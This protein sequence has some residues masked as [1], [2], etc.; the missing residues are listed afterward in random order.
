MGNWNS[1]Q[2]LKFENQRTQPAI[3]L[4]NRIKDCTPKTVMDIGCG[5]GNSTNVMKRFFSNAHIVGIDNSEN[6]IERAKAAYHDI[7]FRCCDVHS[8]EAEYDILFSNA[9]L[10]WVPN[11]KELIPELMRR[12]NPNGVLAV[13]F[14]MNGEEPLYQIIKQV[15]DNVKWGFQNV[16]LDSHGTL[17]PHEYF[18]VLTGCSS[19]FQIW[20]T[21]YY[22]NLPDHKALVEWV[23]G[24]RI[25][26]YLSHLS[27]EQG[28]EF[29]QEIIEK[30]KEIYPI[31]KNGQVI[32]CFRRFFFVAMR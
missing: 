25:R 20:E 9:C 28:V 29:E 14:P 13:Q 19:E 7:E 21:K 22:H 31:M 32:L 1:E 4:A 5:P 8:I 23:K 27:E 2:Y 16:E 30:T 11:H 10:Q 26:P 6:M 12:L 24:T 17:T 15:A 18:D 3:D